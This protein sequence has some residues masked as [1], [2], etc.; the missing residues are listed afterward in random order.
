M[1]IFVTG[2]NG[3]IGS[4]L[5]PKLVERG[6]SVTC[7]V[8]DPAKAG[9]LAQEGVTLAK[10]DVT[11]RASLREPMRGAEVVF[12][13]AGWYVLGNI[14]KANMQAINV[15]GTRNTLEVAVE[16]GVPKIIHTSTVGV[17]GNT[18]GKI[19]DETYRAGKEA[20]GSEYERT[21]WAAHY[22]VAV[23]LQQAGA[24]VIIVQP[25][26]VTGPGDTSALASAYEFYLGRTPIM[27]GET[28]GPTWAYV[29]D[30]AEGHIL[31]MEKGRP[32][33]SYIIAGP[34]LTY[35]QV[36][37]MWEKIVGIPAPKL[38]AP[39]W[40]AS[41]MSGLAGLFER[42]GLSLPLSSEAL[43]LLNDYTFYGSAEKAKREL[44]W[45]P[46]PIE[47]TFKEVLEY[48]MKKRK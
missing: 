46:R 14:D 7:L 31:A 17:F 19:V 47:S 22:E 33:E 13:L 12:H 1:K 29:D 24:P 44:G 40:A 36:M 10:G 25:G 9:K 37:E 32:G 38:W 3:F 6:H 42:L 34:S 30:I 39:G 15:D 43:A 35:R 2:G 5:V 48:E 45:Q 41:L 21:K 4:H 23:P 20:M 27:F 16:L 18:H 11:D 28:S 8:R 26:G